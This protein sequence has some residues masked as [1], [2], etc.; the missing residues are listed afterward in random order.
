MFKTKHLET[1]ISVPTED[2]TQV[3][4]KLLVSF[5]SVFLDDIPTSAVASYE[6]NGSKVMQDKDLA[7]AKCGE[8]GKGSCAGR[9]GVRAASRL[10]GFESNSQLR[11]G[12]CRIKRV[13]IMWDV[14][15]E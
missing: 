10:V 14:S 15:L 4:N 12:T 8:D 9:F 1:L 5:S 2:G 3:L 11:I 13:R 6:V 7:L